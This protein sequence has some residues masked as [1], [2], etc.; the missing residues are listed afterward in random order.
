MTKLS[1]KIKI[2]SSEG[3]VVRDVD[4]P[5]PSDVEPAEEESF[6]EG[7]KAS[8]VDKVQDIKSKGNKESIDSEDH[9]EPQFPDEGDSGD[10]KASDIPED[11]RKYYIAGIVGLVIMMVVGFVWFISSSRVD[12]VNVEPEEPSED[13]SY[14]LEGDHDSFTTLLSSA[15]LDVS[16]EEDSDIEVDVPEEKEKLEKELSE[17]KDELDDKD[18]KIDE[19]EYEIE[20]LEGENLG[21]T[22]RL[23]QAEKDLDT[24]EN[25]GDK[26]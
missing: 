24:L 12:A 15:G 10:D 16:A 7:L 13:I 11:Q 5:E 8:V 19:L 25:D 18:L 6:I 21:L 4:R 2:V 1:D 26:K 9:L 17:L 20:V 22:E 23:K 14:I 3:E